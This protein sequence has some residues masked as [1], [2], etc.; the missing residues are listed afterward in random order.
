MMNK[1][2]ELITRCKGAVFITVND[3]RDRYETVS[4]YIARKEEN[5]QP[6]YLPNNIAGPMRAR[7]TI[8]NIIFYPDTPVGFCE[9]WHYDLEQAIDQCLTNWDLN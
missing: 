6:M 2:Q 4:Q 8:V 1:L 7:D 9:V 3:H 5:D